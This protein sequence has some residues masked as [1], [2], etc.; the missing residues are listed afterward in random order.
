M[1]YIKALSPLFLFLIVTLIVMFLTTMITVAILDDLEVNA[2]LLG[3]TWSIVSGIILLPIFANKY[4]SKKIENKKESNYNLNYI[5]LGVSLSLV[6]N[7]IFLLSYN[8]LNIKYEVNN[9]Y[10]ILTII[11]T[12]LIGP[13]LE[14]YLFRGLLFNNLKDLIGIKKSVI[15]TIFIFSLM[16]IGLTSVITAVVLGMLLTYIYIVENNINNILI[17]HIIFNITTI[18]YRLFVINLTNG[19]L[20]ILLLVSTLLLIN[21]LNFIFKI[22]LKK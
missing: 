13:C 22:K 18:L 11:T 12:G 2:T 16:H 9:E 4:D 21:C 7:I 10:L 1:K 15:I 6:L 19:Y 5:S 17:T 20:I 14:E 8:L 3:I